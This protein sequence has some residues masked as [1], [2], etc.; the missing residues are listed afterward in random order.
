ME[1]ISVLAAILPAH[2]RLVL[3]YAWEDEADMVDGQ[4]DI[5]K[6]SEDSNYI[7]EIYVICFL[8]SFPNLYSV[9]NTHQSY[10]SFQ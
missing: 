10:V 8:F 7:F 6:P 2:Q 1:R 4:L 3:F 9:S 5:D